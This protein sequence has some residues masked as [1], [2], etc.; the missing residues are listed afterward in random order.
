MT[1]RMKQKKRALKG[2][3]FVEMIM[4]IAILLIGM[5]AMTLLFLR[6]FDNNKFILEMGNASFL[7]SRGVSKVVSEIRKT[8]QADNGDYP[9]ESGDDFDLKLYIDIDKDNTTERVHYYLL[10]SAL[11][12]GITEPVAGLPITYPSGDGTTE[13]IAGSIANTATDPIFY[14]YNDDYPADL[15][16]NPLGTPV[17]ISN[18]RM[19]KVHLMVNIDPLHAP[20]YVNIESFADLRNVHD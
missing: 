12:R 17:S 3:S 13:L 20:D 4:A 5:E 15:V 9:V 19:I 11:Y 1:F 14:Y 10:N 8:R 2:M 6:S 18:V 16:N 7:A